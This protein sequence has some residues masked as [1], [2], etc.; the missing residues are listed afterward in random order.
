M[1]GRSRKQVDGQA[2]IEG[3]FNEAEV[4]S[5]TSKPDPSFEEVAEPA[6]KA[7]RKYKG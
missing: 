4:E 5:D 1:F 3:L 2:V 7:D 6:T